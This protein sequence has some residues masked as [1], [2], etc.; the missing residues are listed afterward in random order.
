[1][2]APVST[3]TRLAA[4]THER[5][6]D[7]RPGICTSGA[8]AGLPN[9]ERRVGAAGVAHRAV[10]DQIRRAVGAEA[11]R[12]RPVDAAQ[13]LPVNA[14]VD[15]RQRRSGCRPGRA[16]CV[17]PRA[18]EREA[19]QLQL[20]RVVGLVK[21]ISSTS[22][23]SDRVAV[24]GREAEVAFARQQHRVL[25]HHP[26]HERLRHEVEAHRRDVGRLERERRHRRPRRERE[27]RL[28]RA[29]LGADARDV[30]QEIV[31]RTADRVE[32]RLRRVEE[33]E[34]VR[35]AVERRRAVRVLP[36][37]R[38]AV[39]R[40]VDRPRAAL[41]LAVLR[42]RAARPSA[43][44][45]SGEKRSPNGLRKPQ[46]TGSMVF[47]GLRDLRPQDRAGAH[48]APRRA[49]E[50]RHDA[51]RGAPRRGSSSR[52]CGGRRPSPRC[53]RYS[54]IVSQA[55][56]CW[57]PPPPL[58][59]PV[60]PGVG[61]RALRPVQPAVLHDDLLGRMIAGRQP[62]DHRRHRRRSRCSPC[63]MREVLFASP[64]APRT[65]WFESV[66]NSVPPWQCRSRTRGRSP[67]RRA[68]SRRPRPWACRAGRPAAAARR[69]RSADP[70]VNGLRRCELADAGHRAVVVA[71]ARQAGARLEHQHGSRACCPRRR[72]RS[73]NSGPWRRP[74]P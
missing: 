4:S 66:A 13:H 60:T 8:S 59:W 68:G 29:V 51:R 45:R 43:D 37:D 31:A 7:Q 52:W 5:L 63:T 56:S 35:P 28:H 65:P 74:R 69:R 18:V 33:A 53:S 67:G 46:A 55:M 22:C 34:A 3:T 48:A 70:G 38:Q 11:H 9:C 62:G 30:G 57:L 10:V 25:L 42:D 49:L 73:G 23:P 2:P 6:L 16:A 20:A 72:C 36:R 58:S 27:H 32:H 50:R 17:A 71:A 21:L 14:C 61:G 41:V 54:L 64:G 12:H 40:V 44:G 24:L 26:A 15:R 39:G 47:T 1:M 19:R